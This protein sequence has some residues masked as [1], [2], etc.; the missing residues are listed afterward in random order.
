MLGGRDITTEHILQVVE[1]SNN[2]LDNKLT[3]GINEVQL[4]VPK[5]TRDLLCQL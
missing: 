3:K 5:S 1:E 4:S 2:V